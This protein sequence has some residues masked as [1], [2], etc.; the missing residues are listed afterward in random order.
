MVIIN[1]GYL[2][3]KA[4]SVNFGFRRVRGHSGYMARCLTFAPFTVW[5]AGPYG[6][7][8]GNDDSE[9]WEESWPNSVSFALPRHAH[10]LEAKTRFATRIAHLTQINEPYPHCSQTGPT[11]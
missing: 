10:L 7:L 8:P 3:V 5:A 4:C 6:N 2:D 11:V 9:R 1:A